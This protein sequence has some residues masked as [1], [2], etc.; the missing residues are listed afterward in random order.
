MH[1]ITSEEDVK[2]HGH[3]CTKDHCAYM[4]QEL[5]QYGVDLFPYGSEFVHNRLLIACFLKFPT[6][7]AS[8]GERSS[9][10]GSSKRLGRDQ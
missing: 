4:A 2:D 1:H 8:R 3:Q 7:A 6:T 10:I 5:E 9:F